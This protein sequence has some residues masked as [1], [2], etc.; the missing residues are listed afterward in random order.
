[1][2]LREELREIKE[3]EDQL[4]QMYERSRE[5]RGLI[6][7][8]ERVSQTRDL[9]RALLEDRR[10][11]NCIHYRIEALYKKSSQIKDICEKRRHSEMTVVEKNLCLRDWLV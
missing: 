10:V 4:R 9:R 1:M 11:L 5:L 2:N 3:I 8:A 6:L 7:E